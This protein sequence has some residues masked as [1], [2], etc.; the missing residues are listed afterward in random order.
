[1]QLI[2]SATKSAVQTRLMRHDCKNTGL[3]SERRLGLHSEFHNDEIW[4]VIMSCFVFW[5]YNHYAA[6]VRSTAERVGNLLLFRFNVAVSRVWQKKKEKIQMCI[7]L[8]QNPQAAYNCVRL[9]QDTNVLV[10]RAYSFKVWHILFCCT[11]YINNLYS[12][13]VMQVILSLGTSV[14]VCVPTLIVH[15]SSM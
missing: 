6:K 11:W 3:A 9:M 4:E 12:E 8:P 15:L 1:M 5:I 14:C 7:K 10:Q 2:G 13:N